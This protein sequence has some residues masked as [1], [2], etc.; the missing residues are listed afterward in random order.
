[1]QRGTREYTT[2]TVGLIVVVVCALFPVLL[3]R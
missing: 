2:W 3:A 1:M